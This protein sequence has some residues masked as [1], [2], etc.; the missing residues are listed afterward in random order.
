MPSEIVINA[1][2]LE[3]RMAIIE[4]DVVTEL[5][6]ERAR[7]RSIVGNIYKGVVTKVLP[8]MQASF[9]DIGLEKAGFLYVSDVDVMD[10]MEEY[11]K[12]KTGENALGVQE[13]LELKKKPRSSRKRRQS[14]AIEEMLQEG[15]EVMV[16]V[17]KEPIGS[18]G[19]RITS[20]STLPGRYLVYMPTIDN[21]G[22]SRRIEAEAERKRLRDM[23]KSLKKQGAGYI[24]RTVSEGT[25]KEEFVTDIKYL[26]KLWNDVQE[27]AEKV[28][29]PALLH[30]DLNLIL[31]SFRDAYTKDVEKIIMDS[32][33][34]Y[35][36]CIEFVRAYM[37]HVE[38]KIKLYTE[39]EPIFDVYGIEMEIE[40]ALGRK[41]WLKSGGYIVIDQTE[42]LVT[43]DVNT[44]RYV[45]KRNPEETI[46]KT[47]LEAI[48]EIVYQLKLRNIGGII[49]IDFI[50][51]AKDES[52]EKVYSTLDAALKTDKA[53]ANILEVSELG[54]VEMTRERVRESLSRVLCEPCPYCEGKGRVKSA[55]TAC[56]EV[57]REVKR[58]A[59]SFKRSQKIMVNVHPKV[60]D[61]ILEEERQFLDR[62]EKDLKKRIIIKADYDLHLEQYEV[63]NL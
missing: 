49:I 19:C 58:V 1:N 30:S 62:L 26:N 60:S 32:E 29:A 46:L 37:P 5:Y 52:K 43:I 27:K 40:R 3:T 41:I 4:N 47:N 54:L 11:E 42:A 20:Y 13:E 59:N 15:Q 33:E 7:D 28:S 63:I 31:R 2:A 53:K 48:K 24:V 57:F 38:P 61:M 55:A 34:E 23:I 44:G 6:I 18:K 17:S 14:K 16:Q 36:N 39:K 25:R 56:Y 8:G 51:M 21:V 22:I 12:M 9:V 35:K 10:I 45:G 50:D